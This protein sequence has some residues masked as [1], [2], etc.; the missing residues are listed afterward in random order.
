M[1]RPVAD[2]VLTATNYSMISEDSCHL[3]ERWL[4]SVSAAFFVDP[5]F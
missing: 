5:L 3:D 2:K 1:R 4:L